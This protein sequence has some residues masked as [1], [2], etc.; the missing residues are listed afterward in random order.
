MRLL[1]TNDPTVVAFRRRG[2]GAEVVVAVAFTATGGTVEVPAPRAGVPWR[3]VAGTH[4]EPAA[5]GP[6]GTLRLRGY[7]GVILAAGS[8]TP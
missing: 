6:G 3:A 5:L 4:R 1:R 8:P 2:S 7:E